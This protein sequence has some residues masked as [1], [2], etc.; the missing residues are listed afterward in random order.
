MKVVVADE[1]A[2]RAFVAVVLLTGERPRSFV[3]FG[4]RL[5]VPRVSTMAVNWRRN[6]LGHLTVALPANTTSRSGSGDVRAATLRTR[7]S[8]HP[9]GVWVSSSSSISA[10]IWAENAAAKAG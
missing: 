3:L 1:T 5:A 8:L 10:R 9:I 4:T 2:V 7:R 6:S